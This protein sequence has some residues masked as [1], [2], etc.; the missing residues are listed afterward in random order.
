MLPRS[1]VH[2]SDELTACT[3][4]LRPAGAEDE[5]FL[6]CVYACTREAELRLFDW[7]LA[8]KTAFL[9]MQ[10]TAQFHD[11]RKRFQGSGYEVIAVDGERAG[12]LF[13]HRGT[14]EIRL[15]DIGLLLEY[16]NRGIGSLLVKAVLDEAANAGKP[17]RLHVESSN[18]AVRFYQRLGFAPI[19]TQGV[20]IGMEWS[21]LDE[22]LTRW[23]RQSPP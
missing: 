7:D 22:R 11:Y 15:V 2:R 3:I 16:C 19:G 6:Y 5:S 9:K 18:R 20:H 12:R 4:T 10:F 14:D 1:L 21:P 23:G 8:Q 13:I 17:V